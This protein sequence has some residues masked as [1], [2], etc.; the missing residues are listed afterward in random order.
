MHREDLTVN[1]KSPAQGSAQTGSLTR[2]L[3]E[4]GAVQLLLS[5][6]KKR[7]PAQ[8]NRL[9]IDF[10]YAVG[11]LAR[12]VDRS[13]DTTRDHLDL[14]SNDHPSNS[15]TT[16]FASDGTRQLVLKPKSAMAEAK[17]K[18]TAPKTAKTKKAKTAGEGS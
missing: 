16:A 4:K 12:D 8:D 10:E 18:K 9:A 3:I 17:T 2:K 1:P 7:V 6:G 11:L 15:L 5:K 13:K 14:L